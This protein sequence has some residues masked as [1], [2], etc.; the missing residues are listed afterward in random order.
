MH[1]PQLFRGQIFVVM[2]FIRKGQER[3]QRCDG[4]HQGGT[5]HGRL[6]SESRPL[7]K[8]GQS[9]SGIGDRAL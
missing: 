9:G 8:K 2:G 4:D 5:F 3:E 7:R 1:C 6:R